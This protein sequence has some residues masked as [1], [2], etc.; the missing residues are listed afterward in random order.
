[1]GGVLLMIAILVLVGLQILK[2]G[3]PPVPEQAIEEARLTTEVLRN[4]QP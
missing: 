2:R 1:M 4:G 3:S